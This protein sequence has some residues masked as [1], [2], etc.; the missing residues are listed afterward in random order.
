MEAG[1]ELSE[2]LFGQSE[3]ITPV[4]VDHIGEYTGPIAVYDQL[5]TAGA[6]RD[7]ELQIEMEGWA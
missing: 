3:L 1:L 7:Q 5:I 2:V 6:V 4:F